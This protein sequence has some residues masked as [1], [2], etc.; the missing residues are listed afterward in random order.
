MIRFTNR[1]NLPNPFM[2]PPRNR[3]RSLSRWCARIV[4]VFALG[5]ATA[6]LAADRQDVDWG[7]SKQV[8]LK[9]QSTYVGKIV[10]MPDYLTA[11]VYGKYALNDHVAFTARV[12]NVTN[13]GYEPVLGY[14]ALGRAY[15]GGFEITF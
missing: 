12:E 7:Y 8:Y 14:P 15:Y 3:P 9:G 5:L 10:N 13:K 1:P 11:R 4:F 6:S 2:N